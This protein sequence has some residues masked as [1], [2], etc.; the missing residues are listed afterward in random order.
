[1]ASDDQTVLEQ[2]FPGGVPQ[3]TADWIK[4]EIELV[5]RDDVVS[6]RSDEWISLLIELAFSRIEQIADSSSYDKWFSGRWRISGLLDALFAV[7]T[8]HCP[9]PSLPMR[10]A[11][12]QLEEVRADVGGSMHLTLS[13]RPHDRYF[14]AALGGMFTGLSLSIQAQDPQGWKH[15]VVEERFLI[16][17]AITEPVFAER[18][19][20]V[21]PEWQALT[22]GYASA[23]RFWLDKDDDVTWVR[24]PSFTFDEVH[25]SA[26]A[27]ASLE[28]AGITDPLTHNAIEHVVADPNWSPGL[29]RAFAE[30]KSLSGD[31]RPVIPPETTFEEEKSLSDWLQNNREQIEQL[32][33]SV[34]RDMGLDEIESWIAK[35]SE[36]QES[37]V[38]AKAA[39]WSDVVSLYPCFHFASLELGIA[40]DQAGDPA[41]ALPWIEQAILAY[42][43]DPMRWQSLEVVSKRLNRA[44]DAVAAMA[45]SKMLAH[46]APGENA[47]GP[48]H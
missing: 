45:V 19:E 4:A 42:P 34:R 24:R 35:A 17:R 37:S 39:L 23:L 11:L 14:L 20:D 28:Q 15:R 6:K 3:T 30:A 16:P 43:R 33:E 12:D 40:K 27:N 31:E 25:E 21:P 22:S 5:P 36:L 26:T 41:G 47:P 46:G 48:A 38:E 7:I 8:R 10:A 29:S 13:N 44:G 18:Y 32:S 9:E 1:M 2:F